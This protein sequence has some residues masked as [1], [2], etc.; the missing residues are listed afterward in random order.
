MGQKDE[1]LIFRSSSKPPTKALQNYACPKFVA[2][3]T[4]E[5]SGFY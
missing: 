1:F 4:Q 5:L 3:V 2:L